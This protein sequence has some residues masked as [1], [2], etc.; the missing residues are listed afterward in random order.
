MPVQHLAQQGLISA[1]VAVLSLLFSPLTDPGAWFCPFSR[2]LLNFTSFPP[3]LLEVF[4][5]S[6]S[7]RASRYHVVLNPLQALCPLSRSR[8]E[9]PSQSPCAC[10]LEGLVERSGEKNPTRFPTLSHP[11]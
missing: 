2:A 11:A 1:E 3:F 7:D 4:A 8:G 10:Q 9:Q 6:F 5:G